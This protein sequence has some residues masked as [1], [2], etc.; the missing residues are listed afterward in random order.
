M[1]LRKG[2]VLEGR[3]EAE[4]LNPDHPNNKLLF[5]PTNRVTGMRAEPLQRVSLHFC[6]GY[7]YY[8]CTSGFPPGVGVVTWYRQRT[9]SVFF[10][11]DNDLISA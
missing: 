6:L 10:L 11:G 7:V 3:E 8:L 2:S 1:R 9:R 4:M 5:S